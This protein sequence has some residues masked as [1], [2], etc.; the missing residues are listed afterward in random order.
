MIFLEI[1]PM[2][3]MT[4]SV[5]GWPLIELA[6]RLDIKRGVLKADKHGRL[7]RTKK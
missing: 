2:V 3:M 5:I 4:L 1:L 7:C 6:I